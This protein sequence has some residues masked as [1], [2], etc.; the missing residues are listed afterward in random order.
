MSFQIERNVTGKFTAD[1]RAIDVKNFH[2]LA[3]EGLHNYGYTGMSRAGNQPEIVWFNFEGEAET[4]NMPDIE[5]ALDMMLNSFVSDSLTELKLQRMEAI[6]DYRDQ[7][8]NSWFPFGGYQWDCDTA[9]MTNIQGTNMSALLLER[10]GM[11]WPQDFVFR[12][13]SNENVPADAQ[14]MALLGLA[15]FKFR[16]DCYKASWIHKYMIAIAQNEAAVKA[17]DI[18]A[19]WPARE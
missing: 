8:M 6:N 16:G 14:F 13:R 2:A 7:W 11:P 4:V 17:Y 3:K 18:H 1:D 19:G 5:S 12:S 9:G 15:L 10:F